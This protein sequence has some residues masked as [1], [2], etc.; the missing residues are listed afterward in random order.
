MSSD[1]SFWVGPNARP[2]T[3]ELASLLGGGG[4]GEVWRAILP[5][6]DSG[7]RPVAV[8]IMRG[9]AGP[10]AEAE[11]GPLRSSAAIAGPSRPGPSH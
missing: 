10:E 2:E 5:L 9:T 6:S 7:R 1:A 4:E 3:Y 11:L 8:K